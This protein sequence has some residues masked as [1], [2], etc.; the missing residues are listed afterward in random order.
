MII[1][2]FLVIMYPVYIA[3]LVKANKKIVM[4][5]MMKKMAK[6]APKGIW[7][8]FKHNFVSA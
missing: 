4:E 6:P 1:S 8:W 7:C 3:M 2:T 5:A